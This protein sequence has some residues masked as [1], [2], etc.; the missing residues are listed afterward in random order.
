MT[1]VCAH[2]EMRRVEVR[3]AWIT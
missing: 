3:T 1:T 2:V